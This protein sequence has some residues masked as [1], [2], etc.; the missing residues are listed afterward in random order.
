[1]QTDARLSQYDFYAS[2]DLEKPACPDRTAVTLSLLRAVAASG[3]AVTRVLD[4]GCG[5]GLQARLVGD[6]VARSTVVGVDW[7]PAAAGRAHSSGVATIVA[8]LD[9]CDLPFASGTFDV[10]IFSEV[11][12]HLVDTD[13]AISEI[14]RVLAD[15]GTLLISTPNLAAWFNRV[16]LFVGV[17]PLFSEVSRTSVFGRPG[18]QVAGHLRLFTLRALRQFLVANG[19]VIAAARGASYHEIPRP[20]RWFDRLVRRWPSASAVLVVAATKAPSPAFGPGC[21]AGP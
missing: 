9:G 16:L 15:H 11:I 1:M 6:V 10:V 12:E 20:M 5:E 19:F 2:L 4:V 21:A 18:Q 14:R 17:Q 3:R 7:S 13:H 8:A